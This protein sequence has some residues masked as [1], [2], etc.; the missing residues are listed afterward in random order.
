MSEETKRKLDLCP[1]C[2]THLN[3]MSAN[4][5]RIERRCPTC[6]VIVTDQIKEGNN[7]VK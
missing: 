1:L 2:K 7:D 4:K 3:I 5:E 6:K